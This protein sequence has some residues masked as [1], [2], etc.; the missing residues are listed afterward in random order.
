VIFRTPINGPPSCQTGVVAILGNGQT[1][2]G[3]ETCRFVVPAVPVLVKL[4]QNELPNRVVP[5]VACP[6]PLF[7]A[8]SL[9]PLLSPRSQ[10]ASV[11]TP[12]ILGYLGLILTR[13][14]PPA[15]APQLKLSFALVLATWS[16]TVSTTPISDCAP[17][18]ITS[19]TRAQVSFYRTYAL[20]PFTL[21]NYLLRLFFDLRYASRL[22]LSSSQGKLNANVVPQ[23]HPPSGRARSPL[24]RRDVTNNKNITS[25]SHY[26]L[27]TRTYPYKSDS[28][29]QLITT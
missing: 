16:I 17:R 8:L 29:R 21:C 23:C 2:G 5:R 9:S 13:F 28:A 6:V 14:L 1:L 24:I 18:G 22:C 10:P 11:G 20:S 12:V 19:N 27:L 26:R 4:A 3:L 15:I 7:G 25:S